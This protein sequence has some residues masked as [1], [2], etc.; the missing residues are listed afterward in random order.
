MRRSLL[1]IVI[2]LGLAGVAA[3]SFVNYSSR[4]INCKIVYWSAMPTASADSLTYIYGKLQPDTKGKLIALSTESERTLFFD[5]L[6][7]N[8]GEI[9]GFKV[10]L[11]LYTAP[12]SAEYGAS[13][14][15]ILKG[16]DGIVFIADADPKSA[17]A[18]AASL[19]ELKQALTE[20]GAAAPI[21]FQLQNT[22]KK[23]AVSV[24]ALARSLAIGERGAYEANPSTG[25]GVFDTLKDVTKQ[26][27]TAL[28][29]QPDTK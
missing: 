2:L 8:L 12:V 21:V 6:P 17:K 15:L 9:R 27:L 3:A 26:V 11:H 22:R 16:A 29:K 24:E 7:L 23:K 10:R 13:R 19:A 4:E 14:R 1:A 20:N 25:V 18:N 28:K 5:F